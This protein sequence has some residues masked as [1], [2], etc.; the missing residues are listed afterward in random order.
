LYIH[1]LVNESSKDMFYLCAENDWMCSFCCGNNF[2]MQMM[3]SVYM[4]NTKVVDN[5]HILVVLK[6]HYFRMIGLRV[7]SFTNSLSGFAC[8]LCSAAM[9][10]LF[11]EANLWIISWW[12]IKICSA[13]HKISKI[14]KNRAFGC[15]E[16]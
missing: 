6:F 9:L 11:E 5:L 8:S 13:F 14:L 1:N 4:L 3:F 15:L 10:Y 16:L 7:I 2:M 12:Q